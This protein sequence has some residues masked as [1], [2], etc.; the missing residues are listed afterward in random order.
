[1]AVSIRLA[2]TK[3]TVEICSPLNRNSWLQMQKKLETNNFMR[4]YET[5]GLGVDSSINFL[6]NICIV[7]INFIFVYDTFLFL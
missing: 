1:M 4:Q 7:N 2:E 5:C 6:S 3:I